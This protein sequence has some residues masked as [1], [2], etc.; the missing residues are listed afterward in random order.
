M[1]GIILFFY[2]FIS[3]EIHEELVLFSHRFRFFQC[4]SLLQ[5]SETVYANWRIPFHSLLCNVNRETEDAMFLMDF[6][7]LLALWSWYRDTQ[8]FDFELKIVIICI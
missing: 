4:M 6:E 1:N 2:S 5:L 3:I 7:G 8:Y